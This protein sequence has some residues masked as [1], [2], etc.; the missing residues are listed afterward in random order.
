MTR[1]PPRA[2]AAIPITLS[3]PVGT[4]VAARDSPA[5]A[6]VGAVGGVGGG[7]AAGLV[8]EACVE[9]A[10]WAGVTVNV[11][12]VDVEDRKPVAPL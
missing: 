12:V 6:G 9:V 2:I 3:C 7:V 4:P 1:P 5:E 8:L 10:T 11:S